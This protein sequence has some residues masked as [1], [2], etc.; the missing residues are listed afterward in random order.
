[1]RQFSFGKKYHNYKH[2]KAFRTK[3]AACRMLVKIDREVN[4]TNISQTP[5]APIYFWQKITIKSYKYRKAVQKAAFKMFVK[6]HCYYRG[7]CHQQVCTQ[8]G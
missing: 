3:K 4:F 6:R 8:P 7:Q 5:F 1:L 2:I